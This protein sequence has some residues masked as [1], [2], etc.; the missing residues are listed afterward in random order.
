MILLWGDGGQAAASRSLDTVM[1]KEP[2]QAEMI[3]RGGIFQEVNL[4]KRLKLKRPIT[5]P[6]VYMYI[7][8]Q[9]ICYM[10]VYGQLL[11]ARPSTG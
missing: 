9:Y 11:P 2:D 10:S 7:Y 3:K 8:I 4:C 1:V 6:V 5:A